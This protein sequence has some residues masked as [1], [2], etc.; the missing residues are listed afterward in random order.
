MVIVTASAQGHSAMAQLILIAGGDPTLKNLYGET[1]HDMA[2]QMENIYICSLLDVAEKE[3]IRSQYSRSRS[4][5]LVFWTLNN[6]LI[7][8][9]IVGLPMGSSTSVQ[10][11]L[12]S[13]VVELVH[14]NQRCSMRTLNFRPDNL[15]AAD[16]SLIGG[17]YST[18][19][20]RSVTKESISLPESQNWFWLTEW[21]VDASYPNLDEEGWSYA[22]SFEVKEDEWGKR[23]PPYLLYVGGSWVRRRRWLRVRKKQLTL[24]QS[25]SGLLRFDSDASLS[26]GEDDYLE[27]AQRAVA[28]LADAS[29]QRRGSIGSLNTLAQE[30][31]VY[32]SAI[33]ILIRGIRE[34]AKR[35]RKERASRLADAYL[36]HA[37]TIR[38][39]VETLQTSEP[40]LAREAEAQVQISLDSQEEQEEEQALEVVPS[41][42]LEVPEQPPAQLSE[43][44]SENSF[45]SQRSETWQPGESLTGS[46]R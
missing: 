2:A 27:E 1:A 46:P 42:H 9:M 19:F 35:S 11:I 22:K 33:G 34:D 17:P 37:E 32:K 26:G 10:S 16:L 18:P 44:I 43:R 4:K 45:L 31:H 3:W 20:G 41:E 13:V 40:D 28:N 5:I 36:R 12:H 14:E 25:P 8:N 7:T 6:H 29:N 21:K 30:L 38:S 24:D 39:L 15:N 23:E